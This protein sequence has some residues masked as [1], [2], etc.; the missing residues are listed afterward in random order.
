MRNFNN[1]S[2]IDTMSSTELDRIALE[3]AGVVGSYALGY[4]LPKVEP[5][6]GWSS[7]VVSKLKKG[8]GDE[9][10]VI[11][12][13]TD[14]RTRF[15]LRKGTVAAW[16]RQGLSEEEAH[17]LYTAKIPFRHELIPVL[18]EVIDND[19]AVT[20]FLAHPGVYGPGSGRVEWLR[21]WGHVIPESAHLSAPRETALAQM[22]RLLE[23]ET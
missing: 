7:K 3:K 19:D 14:R 4:A 11:L 22:V 10:I 8:V 21:T 5:V 1:V 12:V 18:V 9:N 20:A 13:A 2:G 23:E 17:K 15:L 16:M 6:G